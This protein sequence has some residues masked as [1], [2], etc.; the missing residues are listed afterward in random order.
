MG[1]DDHRAGQVGERDGG[2]VDGHRDQ[3]GETVGIGKHEGAAG[4]LA[5]GGGIRAIRAQPRFL[6]Q[7]LATLG[8]RRVI[9]D[10]DLGHVV[11]RRHVLG[12]G[13]ILQPALG[14]QRRAFQPSGREADIGVDRTAHLAQQHER[15]AAARATGTTHAPRAGGSGFGRL[16]RVD[17]R[18][19]GRLQLLDVGQVILAGGGGRR[20][21]RHRGVLRPGQQ[22][23][24]ERQA[25]VAPEG[26]FAAVTEGDRDGSGPA[27]H[28]LLAG[29]DPVALA[30]QTTRSIAG[31]R[32]DLADDLTD[33][34]DRSS[35]G[36]FLPHCC[37]HPPAPVQKAGPPF[38]TAGP[39][40]R[41][42]SGIEVSPGKNAMCQ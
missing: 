31:Y 3:V 22:L 27:G 12:V 32:M 29:I 6:H 5:V 7:R 15:V 34:T 19:D 37:R 36:S 41:Q 39:G 38:Q 9:A 17:A 28:Q 30:E 25:A 21:R 40:R 33:D 8:D 23:R 14:E 4:E 11:D 2:A 16:G 26:E 1:A 20:I 18:L 10:L 42:S 13:Q 35:H 24:G